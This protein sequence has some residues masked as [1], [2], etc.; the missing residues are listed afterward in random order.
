MSDTMNSALS[1]VLAAEWLKLKSVRSTVTALACGAAM[2]VVAG[3]YAYY[4]GSAWDARDA[5][6]RADMMVTPP[7][8]G[9]LPLLQISLA[10]L[11]VLAISGEYATGMIR[12]SL[13]VVPGR[14]ALLAA[15]AAVVSAVTLAAGC[16]VMLA[17]YAVTRVVLGDRPMGFNGGSL[18]DD[19]PLLLASGLSVTVLA[20]VGLGFATVSRSTVG[21]LAAV[22]GVLFVLPGFASFLPAPWGERFM[23]LMPMTLVPQIAGEPIAPIV[24]GGLPPAVALAA[25]LAYA[26]VALGAGYLA[27]TRR[28][29]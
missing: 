21:G 22:I 20:L 2:V 3:V 19:L 23:Y 5:V 16:A 8:R 11:G 10:V 26:A 18:L 17:T 9:F 1:S 7:E 4:A 27:I 25:L 13:T 15:K 6:A 24:A 29:A 14:G 28:D 12:T